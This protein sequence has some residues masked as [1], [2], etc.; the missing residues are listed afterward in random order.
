MGRL[1]WLSVLAS[2]VGVTFGLVGAAAGA[3]SNNQ[4]V[5]SATGIPATLTSCTGNPHCPSAGAVTPAGFWIWSEPAG[6]NAYGEST[7]NGAGSLYFYA[8]SPKE[9]A[10]DVSNVSVTPGSQPGTGTITE[11]V[12]GANGPYSG[13]TC[14]FEATETSPG[15]GTVEFSC[16]L[17]FSGATLT[18]VSGPTVTESPVSGQVNISS[19]A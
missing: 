3:G 4:D 17:T 6:G 18:F 7:G 13:L 10:V 12:T 5:I 1:K 14:S 19:A 16:T 9:E 15:H 11:T 2:V 8:L